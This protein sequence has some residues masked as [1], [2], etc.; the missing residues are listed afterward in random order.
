MKSS[1][2]ENFEKFLFDNGFVK[3]YRFYSKRKWRFD[4][5]N[6]ENMI[7][8]E[9]EG[10]VWNYGRHVRGYGYIKDIEKYNT[11]ISLGWKVFRFTYEHLNKKNIKKT[12]EFIK[13]NLYISKKNS[14]MEK[15]H[16]CNCINNYFSLI[17]EWANERDLYKNSN[18]EKQ[19]LKF[20]EEVGELSRALLKNDSENIK[21]AIGDCVVVL[22]NLA[23]MAGVEIEECISSAYNVIKNRKGKMINGV[24]VK[25]S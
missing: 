7:A 24:Y 18:A 9:I 22:T 23:H 14:T 4:Y 19:F 1:N 17:R 12:M 16:E 2:I 11:A 21:D 6:V 15:R 13:N 5:A 10:G 8:I 3:E 20:M 25:N